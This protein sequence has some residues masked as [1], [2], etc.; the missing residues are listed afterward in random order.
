METNFR[1]PEPGIT[2]TD[3]YLLT[4]RILEC[5]QGLLCVKNEYKGINPGTAEHVLK[6]GVGIRRTCTQSQAR[7]GGGGDPP[8]NF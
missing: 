4:D 8:G 3:D 5:F 1:S 6:W 7:G 2:F